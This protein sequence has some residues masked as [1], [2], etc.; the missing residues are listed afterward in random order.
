M[1]SRRG[2][3]FI[4]DVIHALKLEYGFS[5]TIY[6]RVSTDINLDTGDVN[7]TVS[8][9]QVP[10]AV[11]L[12]RSLLREFFHTEYDTNDRLIIIDYNDL[13]G[14]EVSID[15]YVIFN[16]KKYL[17]NKVIVY[18]YNAAVIIKVKESEGTEVDDYF[19][20][21]SDLDIEDDV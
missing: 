11:I 10:R 14:F 2:T 15:D 6:K 12:P 5:L 9:K 19:T 18:D 13:R 16:N 20:T 7:P 1:I 8:F 3:Q 4:N 17:V 21:T